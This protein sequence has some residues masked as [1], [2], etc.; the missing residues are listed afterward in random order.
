MHHMW[1]CIY[2]MKLEDSIQRLR[3]FAD[4]ESAMV[5]KLRDAAWLLVQ[6]VIAQASEARVR[7]LPRGYRVNGNTLECGGTIFGE[8]TGISEIVKLSR[9]VSSGWLDEVRETLGKR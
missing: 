2:P 5:S 6:H 8:H 9:D 1:E 3:R 4:P 7:E